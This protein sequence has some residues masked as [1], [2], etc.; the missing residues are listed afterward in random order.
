VRKRFTFDA[1]PPESITAAAIIGPD[2]ARLVKW[3]LP[4][5]TFRAAIAKLADAESH[6]IGKLGMRR[7]WR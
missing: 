1:A 2:L 3:Q 5:M 7:R 6:G 4:D